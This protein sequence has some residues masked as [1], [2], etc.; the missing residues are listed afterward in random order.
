MQVIE[1]YSITNLRFKYNIKCY[2]SQIIVKI[3]PLYY[4][5]SYIYIHTHSIYIYTS[6]K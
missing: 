3:D 4:T 1:I 5:H 2:V 6:P